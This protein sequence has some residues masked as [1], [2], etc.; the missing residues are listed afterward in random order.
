MITESGSLTH[1]QDAIA[2]SRRDKTLECTVPHLL[3]HEELRVLPSEVAAERPDLRNVSRINLR[4]R[5]VTRSQING[6]DVGREAVN[7]FGL[8]AANAAIGAGA[9]LNRNTVKWVCRNCGFGRRPSTRHSSVMLGRLPFERWLPASIFS[10]WKPRCGS[11]RRGFFVG[12]W[13]IVTLVGW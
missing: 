13:N 5:V 12:S 10:T 3:T 1:C 4:N 11:L 6:T 7:K 8:N 9:E 2:A